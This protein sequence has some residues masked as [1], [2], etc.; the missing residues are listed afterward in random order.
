MSV[1]SMTMV[2]LAGPEEMGNTAIEKLVVNKQFHPLNTIK[3]FG[4]EEKL[5]PL[6]SL[7]PFSE[8]LAKACDVA[9]SLNVEL[10]YEEFSETEMVYSE[11]LDYLNKLSSRIESINAERDEKTKTIEH[12]RALC[13]QLSHY[14][15]LDV[16]LNILFTAKYQ[17]LRFGRI[18][19][20]MFKECIDR[21]SAR[22][23]TYFIT[24]GRSGRWVYGV[25][26]ALPLEYK[27][28]DGI[29]ATF[30]FERIRLDVNGDV[31]TTAEEVDKRL[32]AEADAAEIRVDELNKELKAIKYAE[33]DKI[34]QTY[35]WL[36]FV[37][38][39]INSNGCAG[40]KDGNF[41]ILGWIP[42]EN[43]E[44][45]VNNCGEFSKIGC[46][47]TPAKEIEDIEPP[48]KLKRGF[49]SSIYEPFVEMF[50]LPSKGEIDPRLFMLLTYTM[51][52]GIM[53]GDV[54][55]GLSLVLIGILLWKLKGVSLGRIIA[56]CGISA[57]AFGF[58]Y[59]SVFGSEEILHG[60]KVLEGDNTMKI[61]LVAVSVGVVL[62]CICMILNIITGIRQRDIK[63]IFFSPN[64]LAG[65]VLYMGLAGG[66]MLQIIKG[67]SVFTTPYILS[68]IVLPIILIYVGTPLSKLISGEEDWKPESVGM[69]LVEGFFELFETALG[70]LSNTLSFLRVGAFAISHAGMMMVVY[71]LSEGS[72]GH[73]SIGGLIFGNVLITILES[74]L[75]CIQ[76]MRLHY[77]EMFGR[78]YESGGVK[79][80]PKIINYKAVD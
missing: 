35:S 80:S 22:S 58:V 68:V 33:N 56:I 73:Y 74:V 11:V 18:P 29:F 3:T 42:S 44:D 34:L 24:S 69:F 60:F 45:Y 31:E 54:G 40:R 30:G 26:F 7:N 47:L 76:V 78:F 15:S 2:M 20:E 13:K 27:E 43:E 5:L 66:V 48:V 9:R 57:T 77:Y 21:V 4:D 75:V 37:S 23:D 17:K 36:R 38:E 53:F 50:G 1:E 79:F 39:S 64:G 63:K 67:I 55:Q 28:V 59:G 12:N 41:F 71:L 8:L 65:F 46:F 62:I 25:Y 6:D 10:D 32:N 51:L 14:E 72:G 16:D 70:Y 52:F 19:V 49:L 61:L